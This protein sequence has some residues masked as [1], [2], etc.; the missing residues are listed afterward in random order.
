MLQHSD[1]IATAS[2]HYPLFWVCVFYHLF[3]CLIVFM[4]PDEILEFLVEVCIENNKDSM[5][6]DNTNFILQD[7]KKIKE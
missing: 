7:E 1:P 2:L 5:E 3:V 6:V 4:C